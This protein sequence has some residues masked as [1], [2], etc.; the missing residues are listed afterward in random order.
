MKFGVNQTFRR[1]F[2]N[3]FEMFIV[4]FTL[5]LLSSP[6]IGMIFVTSDAIFPHLFVDLRYVGVAFGCVTGGLGLA[7][8]VSGVRHSALPGTMAYRLTHPWGG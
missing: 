2:P 3:A 8:V 5:I 1:Y 6:G 7:L 4:G